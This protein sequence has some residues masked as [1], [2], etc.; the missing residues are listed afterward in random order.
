MN[1]GE[2]QER[3]DEL[4][5]IANDSDT[6]RGHA[7]ECAAKAET[8]NRIKNGTLMFGGPRAALDVYQKQYDRSM[9]QQLTGPRIEA[10]KEY[11]DE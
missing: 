5:K 1:N 6:P 8:F 4:V 3:I 10:L 11:L 9:S 7:L 2:L